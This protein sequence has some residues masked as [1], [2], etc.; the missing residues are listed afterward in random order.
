MK[1]KIHKLF[2]AKETLRALNPQPL[3]DVA[4]GV[5]VNTCYATCS[6]ETCFQG[7][8]VRFCPTEG[9]SYCASDC[10]C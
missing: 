3:Q 9:K 4:G 7:C 1:K 10:G 8:S 2:L 6:E 5:T